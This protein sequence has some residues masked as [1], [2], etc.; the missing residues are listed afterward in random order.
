MA[1]SH[2][3]T[4]GKLVLLIIT[5]PLL[6]IACD[7]ADLPEKETIRPVRTVVLS[8]ATQLNE[9]SFPGVAKA[10]Q[11]VELSFRVAGPLIT[12]P[13][14]VGDTVKQGD[15]LAQIDPRDYEM[16]LNNVSGQL[17]KASANAKHAQSEYDREL[18]I[19]QQDAG[20]TSQ[21]AVDRKESQR[22]KTL[23][24][25][26]SIRASRSSAQDQLNYTHLKAPF[27]GVIVNT[28]VTN[29]ESVQAG[30][31]ILRLIDDSSIEMVINVPENLISQAPKVNKVYVQF[32]AFAQQT[33]EATVKEIGT[34]AS[35]STRTYPITLLMEQPD[36]F[37]ILPGM[38][39]K[40]M[41]VKLN[42]GEASS[43]QGLIIPISALFTDP[44]TAKSY[45][46]VVSSTDSS[47]SKREIEVALLTKEG[48][49]VVN[50]VEVSEVVVTAGVNYLKQGQKVR[51]LSDEE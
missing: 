29:Y 20:A 2:S 49:V 24:D 34:E 47:V 4:N 48:A 9:R 11:E 17:A 28:Y 32:D 5:L 37:K 6:L 31:P 35:S 45:V 12:L 46:W 33:L 44:D 13:V 38:S 30:A 14:N 23:A 51:I 50:G 26:A 8:N 10:T 36:E 15:T 42:E 3:I 7:K 18:R 40:T 1:I 39:G 22:D 25:I 19:L 16:S 21:V 43:N 41:G 27:D